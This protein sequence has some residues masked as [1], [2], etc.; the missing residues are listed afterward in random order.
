MDYSCLV[1][2]LSVSDLN[3]E[4]NESETISGTCLRLPMLIG[5]VMIIVNITVLKITPVGFMGYCSGR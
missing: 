2:P 1:C 3:T 4:I 5:I